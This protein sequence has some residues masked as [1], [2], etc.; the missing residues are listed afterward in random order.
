MSWSNARKLHRVPETDED[1]G[2]DFGEE[3]PKSL[4]FEALNID[5]ETMLAWLAVGLMRQEDSRQHGT[6]RPVSHLDEY[7][8]QGWNQL[9]ALCLGLQP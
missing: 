5:V 9:Y 7:L 8:Q 3:T 6:N 4:V 1:L 2:A